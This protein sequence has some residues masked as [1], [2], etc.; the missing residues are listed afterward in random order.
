M[1]REVRSVMVLLTV[2]GALT[3]CQRDPS[4][5]FLD[6]VFEGCKITDDDIV[7]E[8]PSKN[9]RLLNLGR[10]FP[11]VSC[12]A[13]LKV[14]VHGQLS[15]ADARGIVAAAADA[16]PGYRAMSISPGSDTVSITIYNGCLESSYGYAV[17]A[18][19]TSAGWRLEARER[20]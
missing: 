3:A 14:F 2:V 19:R 7:C 11:A 6:D 16:Y 1:A 4:T 20:W 15:D 18:V 17:P 5:A 10:E 12:G 8:D 9:V 13:E